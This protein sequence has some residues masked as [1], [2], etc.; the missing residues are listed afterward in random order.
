MPKKTARKKATKKKAKN[1]S[2]TKPAVK[3][4]AATKKMP[5]KPA[6]PKTVSVRPPKPEGPG[7]PT[8]L[9]DEISERIFMS[10]IEGISLRKICM[11]DDMPAITTVMRWVSEGGREN[12]EEG[13]RLFREQY[14]Q[15]QDIQADVFAERV[16][17][18]AEAAEMLVDAEDGESRK[19]SAVVQAK[20]LLVDSLKWRAGQQSKKWSPKVHT[21]VSGS[22][23]TRTKV[24]IKDFTGKKSEGEE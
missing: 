8:L 18:E 22:L 12:P 19:S 10:M 3:K 23:D 14:A 2:V 16:I 15:A 9:S 11:D 5:S 4:K 13:K 1:K 7:R 20:K 21:E 6:A 24:I 17:D